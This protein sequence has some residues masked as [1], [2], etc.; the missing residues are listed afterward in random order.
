MGRR[1]SGFLGLGIAIMKQALEDY[2]SYFEYKR[3]IEDS[4]VFVTKQR[5][6]KLRKL[7]KIKTDVEDW[8]KDMA[9]TFILVS[10]ATGMVNDDLVVYTPECCQSDCLKKLNK[11][12]QK[13]GYQ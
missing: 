11:I 3:K 2:E 12:K 6:K 10:E 5:K 8:I 7:K 4:R 1:L 13:Y 9:W